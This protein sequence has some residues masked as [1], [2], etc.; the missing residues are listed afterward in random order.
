MIRVK[1]QKLGINTR[2]SFSNTKNVLELPNLIEV[3]TKSFQWFLDKGL[4]EV[5]RD[6]SPIKDHTGNY[7]IEFLSY[8][9]DQKPR[10]TIEECKERDVNYE[11]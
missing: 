11:W 9:L 4:D 3:Q 10:Y 1:D 2:K 5:L 6:V 7:E 8:S